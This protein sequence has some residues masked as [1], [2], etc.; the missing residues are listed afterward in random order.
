MLNEICRWGG[1]CY[2]HTEAT[3]RD[4]CLKAS[5]LLTFDKRLWSFEVGVREPPHI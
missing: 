1:R 5:F 4:P 3:D 2:T